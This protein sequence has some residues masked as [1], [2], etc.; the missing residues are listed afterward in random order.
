VGGKQLP[1]AMR[2]LG[3]NV[4]AHQ[5]RFPHAED[6]IPILKE[7]GRKHWVYVA[8]DLAVRKNPAELRA[9][10]EARIHAIFLHGR[11]RPASYIIENFRIALPRIVFTLTASSVPVHLMITAGGR[12][13]IVR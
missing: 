4:V 9:L 1:D 2:A 13:E 10:H 12:V 6:D 3:L 5:E 11:R 8:K 7:C